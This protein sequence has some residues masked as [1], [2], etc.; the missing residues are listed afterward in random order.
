MQIAVVIGAAVVSGLVFFA[1][2]YF[3]SRKFY[4]SA[5]EAADEAARELKKAAKFEADSIINQA[6]ATAKDEMLKMRDEFERSTRDTRDELQD[7]ER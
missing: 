1:V 3:I 5:A 4:A 6:K 7:H 2:G